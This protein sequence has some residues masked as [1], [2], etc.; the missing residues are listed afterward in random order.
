LVVAGAAAGMVLAACGSGS[1]QD[2]HEPNG[3]FSVDV[4]QAT[5]PTI[6]SLSQHSHLV[7]KVRN[8]EPQRTIPDIAV[9]IT[10][11][12]L[13]TSAQAFAYRLSS[14]SLPE[15]AYASRPVW[16]IDRGPEQNGRCQ[17]SCQQGGPG[18]A[19][20]AYSNTWAMGPLKPGQTATFDW[21]LTAVH[22]GVHEVQY[23]IAAGLN[24]KAKAVLAG[25]G[26]PEGTFTVTVHGTPQQSYVNDQG[27]VVNS[28]AR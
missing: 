5:F 21:A 23:Q 20:T 15:L 13:G 1:R 14:P 24:G 18:G 27:Q 22:A 12:R 16:I 9:T 4:Q 28:P 8:A 10:D 11:P 6:Q 7:I 25:G 2:A 3:N 26:A 19:V 17:Y